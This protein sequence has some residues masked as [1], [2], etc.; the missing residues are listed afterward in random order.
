MGALLVLWLF[1][2]IVLLFGF[3]M[4]NGAWIAIEA[5]RNIFNKNERGYFWFGRVLVLTYNLIT[6]S[7][8]YGWY[9]VA[10]KT[11]WLGL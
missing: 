2:N 7:T 5:H 3:V 9:V 1:I 6:T 10:H 4:W 8:C 11:N